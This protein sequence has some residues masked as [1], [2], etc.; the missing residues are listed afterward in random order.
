MPSGFQQDQNQLKP[1]YY[2]VVLTLSG[3]TGNYGAAA[4]A[5]GAVNPYD[6]NAFTTAPSSLANAERLARGN[7]RWQAILE[8]LQ[9]HSD[10][11]VLDVEVS[12]ADNTNA[13]SVPTAVAFTV[14]YDRDDF[15]LGALNGTTDIGGNLID[16]TVKA[17]KHLVVSGIQRGGTSGATRTY[18][19][20]DPTDD[21]ELQSQITIARPDVNADV[22]ADVAVNRLDGTELTSVV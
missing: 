14:R 2:R 11:Q 21:T 22:Y 3:G 8:E 15:V 20:F 5:N 10:A 12:S 18:R 19:V 17:I 7:L 13:N 9:K 6:W 4:P 1:G 16:T